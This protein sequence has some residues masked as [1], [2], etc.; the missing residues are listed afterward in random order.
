M[1]LRHRVALQRE[2]SLRNGR[3][4]DL[5]GVSEKGDV[6]IVEVKCSRADLM[7]D[8]KWPDYLDHCDKYYWALPPTLDPALAGGEA[9]LPDRTGLIVADAYDAA[10]LRPAARHPLAPARRKVE[11]ERLAHLAMTR[12]TRIAD[13]ELAAMA[14]TLPRD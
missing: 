10:I 8:G 9:F 1:F 7:G 5:M 3:R 12:L 4:A 6:V 13:P 2:V 14:A 11:V